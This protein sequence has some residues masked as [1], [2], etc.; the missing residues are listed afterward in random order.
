MQGLDRIV[1]CHM[2][3]LMLFSIYLLIFGQNIS[4]NSW[5]LKITL[6][7]LEQLNKNCDSHGWI[8]DL[9]D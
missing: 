2:E 6:F 4:N 5:V 9:S 7:T 1:L 8:L 3:N